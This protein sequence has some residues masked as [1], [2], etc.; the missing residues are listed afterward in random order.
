MNV[1]ELVFAVLRSEITNTPLDEQTKNCINAKTA[2]SVY[3]MMKAHDLSHFLSDAFL[4]NGLFVDTQNGKKKLTQHRNRAVCRYEQMQYEIDAIVG[5]FEE[6]SIPHV[7]LKGATLRAEYPERWMRTSC[8]VD[9]LVAEEHLPKAGEVLCAKLGYTQGE[10]GSHDV[11]FVAESG[12]NLELH[13]SL[14]EE[15]VYAEAS[16]IL[17]DVWQHVEKKDGANSCFVL[18]DEFAYFY[19]V[20]HMAKHFAN[21]GCGVRS[22]LDLWLLNRRGNPRREE[23]LKKGRLSAFEE[24]LR[25]LSE[26]W[27]SGAE[28]TDLTRET[29]KFILR[30][31][32]YGTME[33][34]V[35]VQQTKKGG[36][37]RYA[38]SRIFLPYESL[39]FYYPSLQGR[40]WLTPIYQVRRWGRLIFCGGMKRSLKELE[41]N[42]SIPKEKREQTLALLEKL[43][44]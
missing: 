23:L 36:K 38:M 1:T 29:G 22:V 27:F 12:V 11:R 41:T 30:G 21:G 42:G 20:A 44:I 8:D 13:Y 19:H 9:I 34:R 28:H 18:T 31:G 15:A 37:F 33:N 7:L 14:I 3:Q 32:I 24:A 6:A 39:R 17:Q 10:K 4:K 25:A 5:A 26:V 40:K 16:K 43:G 2:Q 35:A